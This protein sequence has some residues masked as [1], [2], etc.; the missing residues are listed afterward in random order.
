MIFLLET[1]K[2]HNNFNEGGGLWHTWLDRD[3][4]IAGKI[5]YLNQETKNYETKLMNYQKPLLKI[6]NLAIHL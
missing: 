5:V 3:L 4:T 2:K 1:L 6:P